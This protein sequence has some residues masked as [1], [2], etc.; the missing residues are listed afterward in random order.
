MTS[1][2]THKAIEQMLSI[3]DNYGLDNDQITLLKQ[4][5]V[6]C[7]KDVTGKFAVLP[8]DPFTIET[9]PHGHGDVHS[10]LYKSGVVPKWK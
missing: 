7:F 2:D 5:K 10:L 6:P 3:N 4:I 8:K 9:K 1:D